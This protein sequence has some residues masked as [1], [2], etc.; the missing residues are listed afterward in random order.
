MSNNKQ[1]AVEWLFRWVN[2]NPEAT[3]KGYAEA[4]EQANN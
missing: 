1:T 4:F 2:D 3:H